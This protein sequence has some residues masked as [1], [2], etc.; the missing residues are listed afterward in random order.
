MSI[1]KLKDNL[2]ISPQVIMRI[3]VR[4]ERDNMSKEWD[5]VNKERCNV[6]EERDIEI[7]M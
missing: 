7:V 5:I 4:G 3:N 6:N 2:L 1:S